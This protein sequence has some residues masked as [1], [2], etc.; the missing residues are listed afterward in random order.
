M[1]TIKSFEDLEIWK[2]AGKLYKKVP[3]LIIREEVGKDFRFKNNLK[4][5]AGSVMDNIS[6][7]F[8]RDSR[9]EFVNT[10]SYS[11]GST[12]GVRSQ[13]FRRVESKYWNESELNELYEEYKN[14]ASHMQTLSSI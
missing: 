12:G 6:K 9:L 7:G 14:L 13:I 2:E 8:E 3:D 4:E 1:A 10:L 11:K 5:A